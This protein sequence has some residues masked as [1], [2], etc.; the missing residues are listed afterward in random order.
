MSRT[1]KVRNGSGIINKG[2]STGNATNIYR[3]LRIARNMPVK[4]LAVE[5]RVTNAYINAIENGS[6]TPSSR[7]NRD[8]AEALGVEEDLILN[9]SKDNADESRFEWLM[10][11]L[12]Q[13]IC[14]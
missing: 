1:M 9:F 4:D 3:L 10:L 14:W 11:K 8:Y 2:M 12:L 6:R 5:L 7:L 13:S